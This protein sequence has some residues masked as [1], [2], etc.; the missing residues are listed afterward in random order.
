MPAELPHPAAQKQPDERVASSAPESVV[1]AAWPGAMQGS[2]ME[3]RL[4]LQA[5]AV[6]RP[7]AER[8]RSGRVS[9]LTAAPEGRRARP[10]R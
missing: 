5:P 10:Q 9:E 3:I 8:P 7:A 6:A 1:P 2:R 4:G